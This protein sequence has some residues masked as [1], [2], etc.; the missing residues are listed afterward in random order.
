MNKLAENQNYI[1]QLKQVT[2]SFASVQ[3]LK[4]ITINLRQGEILG[5]VGENG[6]GKSTLM[7][8][9]GGI[10]QRDSGEIYLNGAKFE[11]VNP[12]VSQNA[13]IAFV[14]QELNLFTN[15]TVFEN[16]FIT[17]MVKS[18]VHTIDKKAMKKIAAEKLK[19]LGIEDFGVDEIVGNLPMGQ[20]QLIEITKAIMK[21]AQIIILDEPTTSLSN[22]EKV[23]LFDIMHLLQKQNKSIIFISHILEDVFEHCDEISVLRDGEIISQNRTSDIS[24]NEVIKQMVGRELNK[25]YPT[26]EKEIGEV[27][28]EVKNICQEGRFENINLQIREGEIVGLFGLMGAG[29]TEL[30]RCLFGIDPVTDGSLIYKGQEIKPVTPENCIKN[31]MAFITENRREEGLLMTKTVKE[32]I[33]LANLKEI[34]AS[35]SFINRKEEQRET[36]EMVKELNIKT[37]DPARQ[38]VIN[39]SG[40]NQQKV[41]FGKWVLRKPQIF[42][43]DE[44]TRGVDVGAKYEIYSIINDLAKNKSTVLLVSSEMEELMG[45]CD[46]ILVMSHNVL[47]GELHKEEYTQERIMEAAIGG[48]N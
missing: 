11:P 17:D 13:G 29:R 23:K 26:V 8:I 14:H 46:R 16:L 43:L 5:L 40:G 27:A 6:A 47:T 20:R 36:D 42:L 10:Y 4:D 33:V 22:K 19:E 34:A 9:L 38:A 15:L 48:V 39:L 21:D 7:N 32:N 1:L 28:F 31:G 18:K 2:K 35:L 37:F 12:K 25:I 30:L 44:P 3:V 41:V 45:M 24:T